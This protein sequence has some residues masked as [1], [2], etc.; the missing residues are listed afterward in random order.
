MGAVT[1]VTGISPC[2]PSHSYSY[3][4]LNLNL[5][6]RSSRLDSSIKISSSRQ[7]AKLADARQ[8]EADRTIPKKRPS[9]LHQLHHL[10]SP[11]FT[12]Y[13]L[14]GPQCPLRNCTRLHQIAPI[15]QQNCTASAV[16]D[17]RT[18][19]APTSP[20]RACPGLSGLVRD[21]FFDPIFL[22]ASSSSPNHGAN[23]SNFQ[24]RSF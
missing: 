4:Y 10:T 15:L 2:A 6:P 18:L 1:G 3:S 7:L 19:H 24:F 13:R 20:V 8:T 22:T 23:C 9:R 5:T 14:C 17:A 12:Y 11:N 21:N 16:A